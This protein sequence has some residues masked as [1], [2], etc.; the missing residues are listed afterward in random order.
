MSALQ[1]LAAAVWLLDREIAGAPLPHPSWETFCANDPETAA[2]YETQ[3]T[4]Y[5]A[6]LSAA[7]YVVERDWQPIATAPRD[8]TRLQ[9]FAPAAE[10]RAAVVRVDYWWVRERGF[11]QMRPMQPYTHWRPLPAPPTAATEPGHE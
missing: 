4:C 5:L 11:A 7:G 6:G 9:C 1:T 3:A 2:I 8:G 10:D